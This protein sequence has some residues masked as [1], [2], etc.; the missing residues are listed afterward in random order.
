MDTSAGKATT[1]E[2]KK[3]H[4]EEGRCY[5]C[6]KQGHLARNCPDRKPRARSAETSEEVEETSKKGAPPTPA[7]RMQDMIARA[8]KFTDEEREAFIQGLQEDEEET[9]DPGFLEA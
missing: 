5:E 1:E 9:E 2:Q 3:K 8:M 7:W 4:R 6:S